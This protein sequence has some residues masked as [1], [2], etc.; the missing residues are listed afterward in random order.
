MATQKDEIRLFLCRRCKTLEEV[1]DFDGPAEEDQLLM[2]V[3]AKHQRCAPGG[4]LIGGQTPEEQLASSDMALARVDRTHWNN[5]KHRQQI[6]AQLGQAGTGFEQNYYDIKNTFQEDALKCYSKHGRP[7]DGC[8]D[9]KN[10]DKELGNA[11]MTSEEKKASNS[12]GLEVMGKARRKVFL[13]DF[14][15]VKSGVQHK[16]FKKA[17][18]YE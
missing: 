7:K 12:F 18:L 10:A 6:L 4:A 2:H 8:I 11:L 3:V 5:P 15:P 17:G 16:V 1:L 13:C 14:C 9:Y